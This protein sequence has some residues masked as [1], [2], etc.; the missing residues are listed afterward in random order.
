[1]EQDKFKHKLTSI[2][3][4]DVAGFSHLMGE[5]EAATVKTLGQY[6]NIM[7]EL[8]RQSSR[9]SLMFVRAL[10]SFLRA[11]V[12]IG[13]LAAILAFPYSDASAQDRGLV[14][15]VSTCPGPRTK[16]SVRP[17]VVGGGRRS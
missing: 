7:P 9:R 4:T 3:S 14:A 11:F 2:I 12:R 5:D 17:K 16:P 8:I 10:P 13:F 1:M 15:E 6:K